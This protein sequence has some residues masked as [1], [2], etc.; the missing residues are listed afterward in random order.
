MELSTSVISDEYFVK[1]VEFLSDYQCL[2][3]KSN[4]EYLKKDVLKFSLITDMS[5]LNLTN[6][7]LNKIPVFEFKVFKVC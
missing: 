7:Q 2:F 3:V 4:T 6:E 5:E 1:L